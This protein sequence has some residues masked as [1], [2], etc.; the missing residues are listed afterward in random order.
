[1]KNRI[2]SANSYPLVGGNWPC[3]WR[4]LEEARHVVLERSYM[5]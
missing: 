5:A 3:V 2:S 1:M 4:G